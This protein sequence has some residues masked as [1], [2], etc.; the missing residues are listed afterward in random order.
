[1]R[2]QGK[3]WWLASALAA[4]SGWSSAEAQTSVAPTRYPQVETVSFR[5]L[6]RRDCCPTPA[7]VSPIPV[8]PKII[9]PKKG[10]T[11]KKEEAPP[12]VPPDAFTQLSPSGAESAQ[13][14]APNMFGDR[15]GGGSGHSSISTPVT[16]NFPGLVVTPGSSPLTLMKS[17]GGPVFL[18]TTSSTP[19]SS[20]ITGN[21]LPL[22]TSQPGGLT[23]NSGQAVVVSPEIPAS[24]GGGGGGPGGPTPPTPLVPAT[25]NATYTTLSSIFVNVPNPGS[26]GVVGRT[27]VADESNPLPRDRVIF[28]YDYFDD[29]RIGPRQQPVNRFSVGLEKTFLDGMTSVEVRLPFASTL[30]STFDSST[31]GRNTELGDLHFTFKALLYRSETLAVA[32]GLGLSVPTADDTVV[33]TA[34]VDVVRVRNDTINLEPYLAFLWTPNQ[35]LFSQFWISVPFDTNGDRV[36][37]TDGRTLQSAGRIHDQTHLFLDGQIGY[38]IIQNDASSGSRLRGLAPFVELHYSTDLDNADLVTAGPFTVGNLANRQDQL[39]MTAG[40]SALLGDA[41]TL[42]VGAVFPLNSGGNRE[43]NYQLGVRATWLFG[44]SRNDNPSYRVSGF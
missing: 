41:W 3:R 43:F 20:L 25:A 4:L 27:K 5:P 16:S 42:S 12:V 6:F 14:F 44:A 31:G 2:W 37:V 13:T 10:E 35:R 8:E 1:M 30:D 17:A 28:L 21:V 40:F 26:G 9:E 39:N 23:I 38:W 29:V 32:T 24:P 34:G 33:R 15:F 36:S 18:V 22:S 19:S 11:P 7:P